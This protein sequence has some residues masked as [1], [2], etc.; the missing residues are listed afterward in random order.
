MAE[1]STTIANCPACGMPLRLGES[2]TTCPQCGAVYRTRPGAPDSP[3]IRVHPIWR[4]LRRDMYNR[5]ALVLLSV[6]L[7][8][9]G[10]FCGVVGA[11]IGLVG[12]QLAR[13]AA[14][15]A[16]RLSP[17]S[18]AALTDGRPGAEALIEGRVS[19]RNRALAQNMVA[20]T[21]EVYQGI[22]EDGDAIWEEREGQT[23]RLRV[24]L[25]DGLVELAEGGY[26]LSGRLH[27]SETGGE[28]YSG[29]M[30]GDEIMAFGRLV[31]GQEEI[32][33]QAD[34]VYAGTRSAYLEDQREG[35]VFSR[36]AG[37]ATA[38]VGLVLL[39]AGAAA[40]HFRKK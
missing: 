27:T 8:S 3:P 14:E 31:E 21:L 39:L 2:D 26:A 37:G 5:Q 22:D 13:Q 10:L 7:V 38:L 18:A 33:L 20:Y 4:P 19:G 25:S 6:V 36:A 23:P 17:I 12:P 29:L 24:E 30:A 40:W 11:L 28:R 35:A 9:V 34:L 16:E 32:E 15:R 1:P